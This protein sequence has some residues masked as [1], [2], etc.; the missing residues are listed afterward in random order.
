MQQEQDRD[1]T[2]LSNSIAAIVRVYRYKEEEE[3]TLGIISNN[4]NQIN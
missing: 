3:I 2:L 4:I 1:I